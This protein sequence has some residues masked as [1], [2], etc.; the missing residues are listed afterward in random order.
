MRCG[1]VVVLIRRMQTTA[2]DPDL[3]TV[4]PTVPNNCTLHVHARGTSVAMGAGASMGPDVPFSECTIVH[5]PQFTSIS[6]HPN[7]SKVNNCF[8]AGSLMNGDLIVYFGG[9]QVT[10]PSHALRL[11]KSQRRELPEDSTCRALVKRPPVVEVIFERPAAESPTPFGLTLQSRQL[12]P[13]P[14]SVQVIGLAQDGIAART[15]LVALGSEVLAIDGE[16]VHTVER[17]VELL[18]N[19]GCG[20]QVKLRL[21]NRP[22]EIRVPISTT[23][24]TPSSATLEVSRTPKVVIGAGD[25]DIHV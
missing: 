4:H 18:R 5:V 1:V 8:P 3:L 11:L 6:L 12:P 21:R 19:V 7:S 14:P 25:V 17:T 9:V 22:R 2:A 20:C 15:N 13:G 24:L 10:S 23:S 16:E